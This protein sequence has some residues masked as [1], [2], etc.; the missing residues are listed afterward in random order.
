MGV[1]G[2]TKTLGT[3]KSNLPRKD[4]VAWTNG[5]GTLVYR[6]EYEKEQYEKYKRGLEDESKAV[7]IEIFVATLWK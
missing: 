5:D 2:K 7:P 1:R 3:V 6:E 4:C